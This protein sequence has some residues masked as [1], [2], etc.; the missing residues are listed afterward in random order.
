M[1]RDFSA[2]GTRLETV[3]PQSFRVVNFHPALV[4]YIA[5]LVRKVGEMSL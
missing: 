4:G 1:K 2:S 3:S 5:M